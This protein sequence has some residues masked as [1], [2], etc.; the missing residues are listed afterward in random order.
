[1]IVP[2]RDTRLTPPAAPVKGPAWQIVTAWIVSILGLTTAAAGFILDHFI[3]IN[4]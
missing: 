3:A 2:Y 1:M 4:P